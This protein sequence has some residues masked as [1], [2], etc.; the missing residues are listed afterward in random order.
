[1]KAN[2]IFYWYRGKTYHGRPET[3]Q[4][5]EDYLV[6][7]HNLTNVSDELVESEWNEY[8]EEDEVL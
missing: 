1:M 2:R 8:V 5:I 3:E 6:A 7:Q 4:A